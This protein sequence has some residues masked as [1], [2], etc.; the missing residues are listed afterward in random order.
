MKASYDPST[1]MLR[2]GNGKALYV[3]PEEFAEYL[4]KCKEE[5]EG[6]N[7]RRRDPTVREPKNREVARTAPHDCQDFW[8][9]LYIDDCYNIQ[10][11]TPR[12][13]Y[14]QTVISEAIQKLQIV[15][16]DWL[17]EISEAAAIAVEKYLRENRE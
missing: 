14:L 13:P 11:L 5:S 4:A 9:H 15:S 10:K 7:F 6:P 1:Q 3:T 17:G 2:I 12:D 8:C 16:I